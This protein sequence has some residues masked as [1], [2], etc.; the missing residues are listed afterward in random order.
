LALHWQVN[1]NWLPLIALAPVAG[2][3]YPFLRWGKG[4]WGLAAITGVL[5]GLGGWLTVPGLIGLVIGIFYKKARGVMIGAI[6]FPIVI[7]M[8]IIF[9]KPWQVVAAAL[10]VM[11][12]GVN[13]RLTGEKKEKPAEKV[14]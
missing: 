14:D 13:R 11:L 8:F 2:H 3:N 10:A 5:F 6:G 9:K 12:L 7:A 4:G 1:L